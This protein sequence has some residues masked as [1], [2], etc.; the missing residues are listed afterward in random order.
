MALPQYEWPLSTSKFR[1]DINLEVR[2]EERPAKPTTLHS[3]PDESIDELLINKIPSWTRLIR[4][5]IVIA[6]FIAFAC[7]TGLILST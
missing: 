5:T 7:S 3:F 1:V 6:L 4:V 2:A